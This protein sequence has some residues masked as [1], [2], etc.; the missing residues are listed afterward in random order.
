MTGI[1]LA[2]G[3][4]ARATLKDANGAPVVGKSV[5]F[6]IA[7][8]AIAVLTPTTQITNSAGVAEVGIAPA[9]VS[10]KGS[11]TLKASA[12]FAGVVVLGQTDFAVQASSLSL[13][14]VT[15]TTTSLPSGGNTP[16]HVTAL[17]AGVPAVGVP[18]N[19]TYTASCG[20]INGQDSTS[21]GVSVPTNG[22]GIASAIYDAVD[23]GGAL[24]SGTVTLAASSAGATSQ[25]TTITVAAPTANAIAFGSAVPEQVFVAGSGALDQAIVKFKVLSSV[26]TGLSGVPVK[27]SIVTN[28]GGVG[29]GL[30]GSTAPVTVNSSTNGD[31]VVSIFSGTI[32]G[33]VKVRAELV[34]SAAIFSESQNL[35]VASG[36][37][38]QRF[39]SLA[40]EKFNIEGWNI[41]GTPTKLTVRVAD[42]QGNAV[43]DGT[44]INFTA[45]GGQ[46]AHSCATTQTNRISSCSVD[47]VSQNPRPTDG[48]VSVFAY[49]SGTK[50]YVDVNADN[51]YDAGD[52]LVQQGDAFRD[53]NENGT[54]DSSLGE[55]VIPRG[56]A[57]TCIGSGWPF[58][59]RLNT[60]DNL[61]DTTVRQQAVLLFSSSN[62]M[63]TV[64]SGP[65][66]SGLSFKLNSLH[67]PLLP[68]PAGTAISAQASGQSLGAGG[69]T[70][71]CS[72]DKIFGSVVANISPTNN[73]L[74][75]L[76]TD[77]TV[78]LKDCAS[79][80]GNSLAV[81]VTTPSGLATTF[82]YIIP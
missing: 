54:Y 71:N 19:V 63:L 82:S 30:S 46:V 25:S 48:R 4:S 5:T 69:L 42:R 47:F 1:S 73:P 77:H 62:P 60:C 67:N 33:P 17:I 81:T 10:S 15:V 74:V 50:D 51:I 11:A 53:D 13:S 65:N 76:G 24:C 78:T 36:P 20:K 44:V 9:A 58:P 79:G 56:G 12:D 41:D 68:M 45:E 75:D 72:V 23:S 28:P 59:S 39:M 66:T 6:E 40:V 7:G 16:L 43:Q 64:T 21:G 37:A 70:V 55:F 2:T 57:L 14:T 8:V 26:G 27:L 80:R 22:A 35:T 38:S 31:V 18:V 52:T 34:S 32:P 3:Y 29:L 61:L 49:L